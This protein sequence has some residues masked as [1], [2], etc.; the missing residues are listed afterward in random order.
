MGIDDDWERG[1][2]LL[3]KLR[4]EER[5]ITST[6]SELVFRGEIVPGWNE[7]FTALWN[8][9]MDEAHLRE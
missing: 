4:T 2:V 6:S 3:K 7:D 1:R 5:A 8:E 9:A